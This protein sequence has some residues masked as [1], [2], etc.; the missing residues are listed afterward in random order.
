MLK[1]SLQHVRNV[2]LT[3]LS[4][5]LR[6]YPLLSY[7]ARRLEKPGQILLGRFRIYDRG[8]K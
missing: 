1:R 2:L 7:N 8:H 4:H 3:V 6:L 5:S